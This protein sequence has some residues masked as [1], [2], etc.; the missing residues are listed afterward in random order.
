MATTEE[1]SLNIVDVTTAQMAKIPNLN[2]N[3]GKN[4]KAIAGLLEYDA[5]G[6]SGTQTLTETQTNNGHINITGAKSAAITLQ[7]DNDIKQGIW[8][9]DNTSDAGSITFRPTG[10]T[11]IKLPRGR[12]IYVRPM[13][14][15]MA[16]VGGWVDFYHAGA[17]SFAANYQVTAG[18]EL[19]LYKEDGEAAALGG[20]IKLQGCVE[21]TTTPPAAGDTIVTLPVGYRPGHTV[22]FVV[23][24]EPGSAAN[25]D[26]VAIEITTAGA[27]IL[28]SVL[29]WTAA[30]NVPIDL[31]SVSFFAEN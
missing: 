30:V 19:T 26:T 6:L 15:T 13:A 16:Q 5:T 31:S 3:I 4:T 20:L 14:S 23:P 18:R 22:A 28:R 1:G 17:L 29:S 27:V 7:I 24:A 21:E 11:G 25:V 10:G 8:V 9:R 2:T 12:W